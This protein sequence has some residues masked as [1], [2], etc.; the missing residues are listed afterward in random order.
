VKFHGN[1]YKVRYLSININI[2]KKHCFYPVFQIYAFNIITAAYILKKQAINSVN[3]YRFIK[4]K[5][6]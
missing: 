3:R 5:L 1:L 2:D 4:I 6:V